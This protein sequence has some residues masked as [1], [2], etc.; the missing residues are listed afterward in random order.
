MYSGSR[1]MGR[2]KVGDNTLIAPGTIVL[3]RPQL[4]AN[5][6]LHGIYPGDVASP[7]KHDV[8]RE[9]FGMAAS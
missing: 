6:V 3:D 9:I 4:P 1:I 8:V 2:S 7:T 5:S